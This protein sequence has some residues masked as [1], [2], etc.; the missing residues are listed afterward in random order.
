MCR[1]CSEQ[2]VKY[3]DADL[4]SMA[5]YPPGTEIKIKALYDRLKGLKLANIDAAGAVKGNSLTINEDVRRTPT[6]E[7]IMD[8]KNSINLTRT[9]LRHLELNLENMEQVMK[10]IRRFQSQFPEKVM[11]PGRLF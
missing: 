3:G 7:T 4:E 8:I 10:D 2:T 9:V 6:P 5:E 1:G 11:R